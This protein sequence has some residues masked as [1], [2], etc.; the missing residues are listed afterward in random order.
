M[1]TAWF[2][3]KG[4][5]KSGFRYVSESGAAVSRAARARATALVLPPAW[6]EVHV[7]TS[8]NAAVQ[9]WGFDAKGRKQYRY[10]DQAVEQGALRK[11]YRVR[12]LGHDLPAIRRALAADF[13]GAGLTKQ[14]VT[15][16][17]VRL[18]GTGF[19][20]VGS[21]RYAKENKTF[22]VTT[23]RKT[24]AH[25][26]GDLATFEYV[27]KKSIAQ[28][29]VVADPELAR[30]VGEL[31]ATPG[32]RL[33]QYRAAGHWCEITARD[34]NDYLHDLVGVPYTA[35]DFRTWGGTLRAATV[36][37]E[38]GPASSPTEAKKNVMTAV[39]LVAAE[40]GN[41]PAICRAS[42]V[43][44]LV[45]GKYLD[46]GETIHLAPAAKRSKQA[47][48]SRSKPADATKAGAH[49]DEER[50]LLRFL[51]EHFPERRRRPRADDEAGSTRAA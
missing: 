22:G 34:V 7:A 11:Y 2:L 24:H 19:F 3:R 48:A 44:P 6:R 42:Y 18:I 27:G 23:L 37:A 49:A 20:R 36:L 25:V 45:I 8:P 39:R 41:T 32:R 15:A 33:F 31:L 14:R 12:Q 47:R 40:L 21:E 43:H 10:H 16:G 46:E 35:K 1:A 17:I 38:L 51:D 9:A 30:F 13:G 5:A 50:A 28:R 26:E 29:Q 4:T